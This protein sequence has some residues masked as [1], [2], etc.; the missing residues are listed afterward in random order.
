MCIHISGLYRTCKAVRWELVLGIVCPGS[1]P[2]QLHFNTRQTPLLIT[3]A[4][5]AG[6]WPL[7]IHASEH[8]PVFC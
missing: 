8:N 7:G 4:P 6:N 2:F 5:I 3:D 1:R